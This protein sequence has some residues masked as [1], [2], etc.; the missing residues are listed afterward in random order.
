MAIYRLKHTFTAGELS[1]LMGAR[2]DFDRYKAGCIRLRNMVVLTQGP[3]TRRPGTRFIYNLTDLGADPADPEIKLVPFVFNEDQ[4][5]ILVLFKAVDGTKKVVFASGEGLVVY[6]DPPPTDCPDGTPI[7]PPPVAGDIVV[8][9]LPDDWAIEDCDHV[10]SSDWVIFAQSVLPP[11]TLKRHDHYCWELVEE[12]YSHQPPDWS[13]ENG[14]PERVTFHQQRLVFGA[15]FLRPKT[16]W[17]SKAGD[18]SSFEHDEA[19]LTDDMAITFTLDSDTQNRIQWLLSAKALMIGTQGDEWTVVGATISA[20]TPSNVL[21][22]R[23]TNVGSKRQRPTLINNTVMF[24]ERH[25]RSLNEFV[26]DYTFDGY[27]ISD[28]SVLAPHLT[29]KYS[30]IDWT[31]Q[32][33]P[34]SI[35]WGVREDGILLGLTYQRQHKVVGWHWHDT[36]GE[37]LKCATIPGETREDDTW[38][39]V[40]RTIDDKQYLYLEKLDDF[41]SGDTTEEGKFL[42]SYAVYDGAPTSVIMGADHLNGKVVHI[43]ADGTVH[44]PVLVVGGKVDLN[45][46]YSHVVIGL[47]F[48]SEVRP[49]LQDIPT[50][51]GTSF[52]REQRIVALDLDF[53]K[54]SGVYIGRWDSE[55][56]EQVEEIAFRVPS[57]LTGAAVPLFTGIY[58]WSFQEGY[59]QS[60][61]YFIRQIQ[62]LP[63]TVRGV[64]D[65]IDIN[66]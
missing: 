35:V 10:Q 33:Q 58:E 65:I 2:L 1:P 26:Y 22:Q 5:Y 24:L 47:P 18:F 14:W 54:S 48:E 23:Q 17:M 45:A 6:P 61:V 25:G 41:F 7:D 11:H 64:V 62:P 55:D 37:F 50:Q 16:V 3:V 32:Q 29:E 28:M 30:L 57:D 20:L 21:A 13:D 36:D 52:G 53:Y 31:Y 63:L 42:D 34:H 51:K 60:A 9:D 46:E 40:R 12:T 59:D 66:E 4:S 39:V 27:K 56:G 49:Y 44:P 19:N 15:N 43:L 38:F 8:L